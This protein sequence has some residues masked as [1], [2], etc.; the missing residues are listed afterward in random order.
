MDDVFLFFGGGR[1][2]GGN[3]TQVMPPLLQKR[4]WMLFFRR[5]PFVGLVQ[6]FGMSLTEHATT[7]IQ[8]V[9]LLEGE[10]E[11]PGS[12]LDTWQMFTLRI[13]ELFGL[14]RPHSL[15]ILS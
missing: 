12:H 9:T 7:L 8:L 3:L 5:P 11:M 1:V 10:A 13:H 4:F 14:I 15:F 6:D 2:G